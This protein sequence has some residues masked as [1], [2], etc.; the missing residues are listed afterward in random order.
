MSRP[1][2][3]I[4][5]GR[6]WSFLKANEMLIDMHIHLMSK[7]IILFCLLENTGFV[8]PKSWSPMFMKQLSETCINEN[9]E[10]GFKYVLIVRWCTLSKSTSKTNA[11]RCVFD[12]NRHV[13]LQNF[14]IS[15]SWTLEWRWWNTQNEITTRILIYNGI[16][17]PIPS[18]RFTFLTSR[19]GERGEQWSHRRSMARCSMRCRIQCSFHRRHHETS[20]CQISRTRIHTNHQE[21][22]KGGP[23]NHQTKESSPCP[24]SLAVVTLLVSTTNSITTKATPARWGQAKFRHVFD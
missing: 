20:T 4:E 14:D 2:Q 3:Q 7:I 11:R 17:W 6:Q 21:K 10:K 16:P 5:I 15:T 12:K 1:T 23:R 13:S 8:L 9:K 22:S 19:I 18:H 24:V